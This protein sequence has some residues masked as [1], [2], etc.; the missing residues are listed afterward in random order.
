[1]S[2]RP[3]HPQPAPRRFSWVLLVPV[4]GVGALVGVVIAVGYKGT[5]PSDRVALELADPTPG[6][7]VLIPGGTFLM[8]RDDGPEDEKPAHE[9]TLAPFYIDK[10]EVTNAQ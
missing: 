1:M 7:M 10:T 5:D 8:G 6:E 9:V 2:R 3:K 4:I